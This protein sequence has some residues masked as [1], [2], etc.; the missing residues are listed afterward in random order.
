[1][2]GGNLEA[3][4][5]IKSTMQNDIGESVDL[6]WDELITLKG[7]L[8]LSSSN[9]TYSHKTKTEES[10]HVFICDYDATVRKL[11]TRQCRL[12]SNNRVYSI[13]H[14]DDPMELNDH[15][16]IF[17]KYVGVTP[18]DDGVSLDDISNGEY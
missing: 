11:D 8:D 1:M 2:I 18:S 17:L 9:T 16:E 6:V 14:I 7:W 12:I 5:Q 15:L 4:I 10:T 3:T 13:T